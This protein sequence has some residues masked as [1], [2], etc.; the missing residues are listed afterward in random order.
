MIN[1]ETRISGFDARSW[2]RLVT[3]VA[4]GLASR[5]PNEW[6]AHA[7]SDGGTLLVFFHQT[8]VLRALHTRR[9]AVE[10]TEPWTGSEGMEALA[11]R[12]GA[13]FVIA[14]EAGALEEFYERIGGRLRLDDDDIA[15]LLITL[16]ALRELHDEGA[17][18]LWP[19][20]IPDRVPLPTAAVVHRALDFLVPD[21]H[22]VLVAL[23]DDDSIDTAVVVD[24]RGGS[25]R[26]VLGPEV[27]RDLVGPLGG[28][29]RRDYRTIRS[30]VERHIAPLAWGVFTTT[31]RLHD[32]LRSSQ[33]SS[34]AE[35][36]ATRDVVI[37]PMPTWIGLAAGA[38]VVRAAAMRSRSVLSGLGVLGALT[39]I[40]RRLR[41]VTESV[42]GFDPTRSIG[43][44]PLRALS[45]ILRQGSWNTPERTDDP[46]P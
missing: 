21:D 36:I 33:P 8:R 17:I 46:A 35:A 38:G 42:T 1:L 31:P 16:G 11:R 41:E 6:D 12:Q 9:G 7:A 19:D 3:V 20:L 45:V 43:F 40:A 28:D 30:A 29:F 14:C 32:L 22:A 27:L 5:A 26:R 24:R 34:W 2:N 39:P 18:A 25:I 10:I 23:F 13:H 15:T 44:N 4:P 37:D